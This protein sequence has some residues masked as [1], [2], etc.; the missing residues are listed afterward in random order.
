VDPGVTDNDRL[1][2]GERVVHDGDLAVEH[3]IRRRLRGNR[4]G[5]HDEISIEDLLPLR[6]TFRGHYPV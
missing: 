1:M 3:E 5:R 2:N 6:R 4:W